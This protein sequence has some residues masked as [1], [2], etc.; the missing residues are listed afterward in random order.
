MNQ[1]RFLSFLALTSILPLAA[2][3]DPSSLQPIDTGSAGSTTSAAATTGSGGNGGDG[4]GGNS[5]GAGGN[6][7]ESCAAPCGSGAVCVDGQCHALVQLDAATAMNPGE[8]TIALDALQVYWMSS[9][10]RRVAKA[11]GQ[12]T[13]LD[14][15]TFSPGGLVVDDSYLYWTNFGIQ[16]V[17]KG[18]PGKPGTGAG[19]Y[20]VD[21][22]GS[23]TRLVG[24]GAT[25]FYLENG[26]IYQAPTAAAPAP[27]A[28]PIP[29]SETWSLA[30]TPIA[31]DAQHAYFWT[32]GATALSR[33]DKAGGQMVTVATRGNS[34][35]DSG[36]GLL[37]SNDEVYYSTAP[38]PG[39]GGLVARAGGSPGQGTVL[40]GEGEGASG[41]FTV[42]A[43]YLY[44]MTPSAVMR[45]P[46]AGGPAV[47]LAPL[48]PP[49]PFPTCIAVDDAHVYWVDGARLMQLQK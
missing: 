15:G 44:F 18:A 32:E 37:V 35:I 12:P 33:I 36:C 7:G 47:M 23:P 2:G 3:C 1:Q 17:E 24:D 27:E 30:D 20:Y 8:C 4:G 10:V 41:V 28:P 25:L 40:V 9:E 26:E 49:S 21:A 38:S 11:G 43:A 48:S 16:R 14:V 5:A 46:R 29:F 13:I 42:D 31:V 22:G 39:K 6:P 19:S 45:M 34:T